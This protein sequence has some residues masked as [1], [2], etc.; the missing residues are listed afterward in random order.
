MRRTLCQA[1]IRFCA[2]LAAVSW[3]PLAAQARPP[4]L[5]ADLEMA[6]SEEVGSEPEG[7]ERVGGRVV[8]TVAL[9][10]GSTRRAL[11]VTDG[12]A[13]GTIHLLP[14]FEVWSFEGRLGG[15]LLVLG[16]RP[17]DGFFGLYRTDG[18]PEGTRQVT[19]WRLSVRKVL[20]LSDR[21]VFF[22]KNRNAASPFHLA[23]YATSGAPAT[24]HHLADFTASFIDSRTAVTAERAFFLVCALPGCEDN[25][26]P[27]SWNV[28]SSDGTPA[29]THLVR[30]V[31]ERR[32]LEVAG[33]PGRAFYTL[34]DDRGR[35]QVW[36]SDGTATGTRALVPPTVPGGRVSALRP[37]GERIA[38]FSEDNRGR[39]A[40]LWLSG[41]TPGTTARVTD[42]P[43]AA[44]LDDL[45]PA[46][47]A[48]VGGAL[49]FP[50]RRADGK[51]ELWSTTGRRRSTRLLERLDEPE[52]GETPADP[53]LVAIGEELL[54]TLGDLELWATDGSP[55]GARLLRDFGPLGVGFGAEPRRV[56]GSL[57]FRGSTPGAGAEV[58]TSDGT[59]EGTLPLTS[60][61]PGNPFGLNGFLATVA[62]LADHFVLA[63]SDGVHGLEPWLTGDVP[64]DERM[65]L[66]IA[67]GPAPAQP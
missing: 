55:G 24:T 16:S 42:L 10:P 15:D 52:A 13:E 11:W 67:R 60:F 38:F 49:I 59:A 64:G 62:P 20:P 25:T 19:P 37:L 56:G 58:W 26:P 32:W 31:G 51:I 34:L 4:A 2:F 18:T 50:R 39:G 48:Q 61:A 9:A 40:E 17:A 22:A 12:T 43:G 27:L 41:G 23:L 63:A 30:S 7:F 47:L 8:F 1:P 5:V 28:W 6:T 66:D 46:E 29:G 44:S 14:G 45:F 54:F 53:H 33:T 36:A 21:V 35:A 65:I 57:L 3:M